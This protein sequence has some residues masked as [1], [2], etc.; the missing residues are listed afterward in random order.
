M[1]RKMYRMITSVT[2]A[3]VIIVSG[4][5]IS[6]AAAGNTVSGD[7]VYREA[8][9]T[10]ATKKDKTT[11]EKSTEKTEEK[12][13]GKTNEKTNEKTEQTSEANTTEAVKDNDKDKN[14]QKDQKKE[15]TTENKSD[16]LTKGNLTAK[17][18]F[19][20]APKRI[21]T[22]RTVDM[23][24]IRRLRG[25]KSAYSK[26]LQE[27]KALLADLKSNQKS[28]EDQVRE[29]DELLIKLENNYRELNTAKKT[30]EESI[31]ETEK[32]L[33]I[34]E[35]KEKERT[36][37]MKQHIQSAYEG[38]S[39]SYVDAFLLSADFM[40]ILNRTEYM[41]Q[42]RE[43]DQALL[44]VY[45]DE[46]TKFANKKTLQSAVLE[47][48]GSIEEEYKEE[49][50]A[51][52]L[53]IEAKKTQCKNYEETID[54]V[55]GEVSMLEAME[56]KFDAQIATMNLSSHDGGYVQIDKKYFIPFLDEA[57]GLEWPMPSS[58][59]LTS[60]FGYRDAPTAG[61]SSY[62]RGVDIACDSGSDVISAWGGVVVYTGYYGSGGITVIVDHGNGLSTVYHHLSAYCVKEGEKVEKSQVIA[63]SGNTG[64][65]TGPH[66]HF[67]VMING[68]YV[69]PLSFYN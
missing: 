30:L 10:D 57:N 6:N 5:N 61:A 66:L 9:P 7:T 18:V 39:A 16:D 36:E 21:V 60:Y 63:Y 27:A 12:T 35:Q 44:N 41:D 33:E 19:I 50:E 38:N 37:V 11:E 26:D 68:E 53:I 31:A 51:I 59:Y 49:K 69:D 24:E 20:S 22:K 47:S 62:H 13:E 8:T 56:R 45:I 3:F 23:D 42:I 32:E 4:S 67:G 58:T 65:S 14:T 54:P 64:V 43:Y 17:G 52:E 48:L 2:M 29:M 28:F 25:N 46:R 1:K 15:E 34:S 40:D 55:E